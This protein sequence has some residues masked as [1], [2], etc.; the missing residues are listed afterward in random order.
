MTEDA[1]KRNLKKEK[2][3][4]NRINM[5]RFQ[6]KTPRFGRG[7]YA[8]VETKVSDWESPFLTDENGNFLPVKARKQ[9]TLDPST[10]E[11]VEAVAEGSEEEG[12]EVVL[13]DDAQ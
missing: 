5:R 9:W 11:W 12:I 10:N 8:E 1:C 13:G 3:T 7:R 2:R 6:K 4:R